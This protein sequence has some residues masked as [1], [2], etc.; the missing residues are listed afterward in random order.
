VHRLGVVES[1]KQP[2]G[3]SSLSTARRP[4]EEH[5]REVFTLG[6]FLEDGDGLVVD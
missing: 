2:L 5:V 3:K 4:I 6:K 1:L